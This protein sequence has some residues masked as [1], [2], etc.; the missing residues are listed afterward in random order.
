MKNKFNENLNKNW[1]VKNNRIF[2]EYVFSDF[3]TALKFVSKVG[4]IAEK[5]NH[6]PTINL[7]YRKVKIES[8]THSAEKL[9]EKDFNLAKKVDK[10]YK[11]YKKLNE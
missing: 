4:K 5:E 10:E 7:S 9:T 2:R 6:H 11:N 3:K 8:F 1:K